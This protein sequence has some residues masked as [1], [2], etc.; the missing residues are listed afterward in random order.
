[1]TDAEVRELRETGRA[2]ITETMSVEEIRRRY[3]DV[4]IPRHDC[5]FSGCQ[6]SAGH[7]VPHCVNPN[8]DGSASRE[9]WIMD[10]DHTLLR[11][12]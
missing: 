5:P 2:T 10:D 3:P 1:M 4:E 11:R 8:Q 6:L 12:I 9:Y 7:P